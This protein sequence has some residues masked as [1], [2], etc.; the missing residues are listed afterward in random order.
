MKLKHSLIALLA[1]G[2][3][4]AA[5][6]KA[7]ET[8]YLGSGVPDYLTV[9]PPPPALGS[10]EDKA[11]LDAVV[12]IHTSSTPE[13]VARS[14]GENKL[15]I[16]HF[17][18]VIGPW[19]LPGKFPKT[20]SLFKEVEVESKTIVNTAKDH[21]QRPR[22]YNVDPAHFPNAI[23]HE[24]KTSYSYPSGHSTRGTVF[25]FLLAELF[26]E[27]REAL[28]EKGR[29]SG[30]LR[31]EGGVHYPED[32]F[33]GRVFGQALAQSFLRNPAFQHEFAAVKAELAAAQK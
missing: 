10:P 22:P 6:S 11:D 19:F 18:P 29:E 12:R 5:S 23:E 14:K 8:K 33:A 31:V 17:A 27:K 26:P 4:L 9:L 1:L 2:L 32:V 30:W 24:G 15:T 13:Q 28:L 21:W 20:E 3:Q 7:E 16:F 25:A